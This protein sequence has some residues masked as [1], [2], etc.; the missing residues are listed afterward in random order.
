MKNKI[1]LNRCQKNL[2]LKL[3][4]ITLIELGV[5]GLGYLRF[6]PLNVE[7]QERII[8][9]NVFNKLIFK[10][11][12]AHCSVGRTVEMVAENSHADYYAPA[13]V[14]NNDIETY[15]ASLDAS[16]RA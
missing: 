2:Q 8:M 13:Q 10:N 5:N 15:Q 14:L 11:F 7:E 12:I 3:I 1:K 6:V 16:R 9:S 4:V